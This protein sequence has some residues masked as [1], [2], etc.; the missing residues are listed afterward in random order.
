MQYRNIQSL[1]EKQVPLFIS[2]QAVADPCGSLTYGQLNTAANKVAHL[3]LSAGLPAQSVVGMLLD[4]GVDAVV[5][6]LGILKAGLVF[7]PVDPRQPSAR[8]QRILT[9]SEAPFLIG[10]KKY[11]GELNRLQ[12]QCP[13]LR[14]VFCIDSDDFY[15]EKESTDNDLHRQLWDH[16]GETAT[17]DISGGGWTSSYDGRPFSRAE[18]DEYAENTWQKVSPY[19]NPGSRVLEIGCASGIT[20]F[21]IAP[22]VKEYIGTDISAA[23][24]KNTG[25]AVRERNMHNIRLHCMAACDIKSLDTEK[26]DVIIINSVVQSFGGLNYLRQVIKDAMDL[27]QPGG[28]VFLGDIMDADTKEEMVRSFK[29][30]KQDNLDPAVVT[31][32]TWDTELFVSRDFL[33]DLSRSIPGI[34]QVDCSRKTGTIA[35]ELTRFRYD[36]I[37]VIDRSVTVVHPGD[38]RKIQLDKHHLIP[39]TADNPGIDTDPSQL[40]YVLYTS[41]STGTPKGVMVSHGS[42]LAYVEWLTGFHQITEQDGSMVI[43]RISYDGVYPSI[44]GTL[45]A[46]GELRMLPSDEQQD[47][48]AILERLSGAAITFFVVTPTL[49]N[50]LL[51]CG[52]AEKIRQCERL[53]LVIIG[54]EAIRPGDLSAFF[55]LMPEVAVYNEY[56]P[57]EATI[58]ATTCGITRHNIAAFA[59]RPV[60]GQPLSHVSIYILDDNMQLVPDNTPGEIYIGGRSVAAGYLNNPA[61]TQEKFVQNPFDNRGESRLY[62]TGDLGR[63]LTDGNI[64]CLGRKDHQVKIR[65]HRVELGEIEQQLLLQ[66]GMLD[67]KVITRKDRDGISHLIAYIRSNVLLTVTD[68]RTALKNNLPD[69]MVPGAFVK[70]DVFPLNSSGKVDVRL[71]PSPQGISMKEDYVAPES[72]LEKQL[73]GLWE[74]VLDKTEI[75]VTENFFEAGGHSLKATRLLAAICKTF[76][77]DV[78]LRMIF[79]HPTIASQAAVIAEHTQPLLAPIPEQAAAACYDCSHAQRRIWV[80]SQL[81]GASQAYTEVGSVQLEGALD[82]PALE[83]AIRLACV[84]HESLRTYFRFVDGELKQFIPVPEKTSFQLR[85]IDFTHYTNTDRIVRDFISTEQHTLFDLAQGPLFRVSVIRLDAGR[86]LLVMAYHH[87]I[88]DGISLNIIMDETAQLYAGKVLMPLRI[89]YKDFAHWQN[90]QIS[91]PVL[92]THRNYWRQQLNGPLPVLDLT[93]DFSRPEMKSYNGQL[94]THTF[95]VSLK[96]VLAQQ[97]AG[98]QSTLF[99]ILVAA[100]KTLLYRYTEQTDIIVG[101]PISGREHPEL[102]GQVGL[103]L[104]MLPLRTVIDAGDSFRTLL[105]KVKAGSAMAYTHQLYPFD[106]LVDELQLPADTSRTPLFDIAVNLYEETEWQLPGLKT[107]RCSTGHSNSKTDIAFNFVESAGSLSLRLEYCADLFTA[108]RMAGMAA[109]LEVLLQEIVH[110]MD[111]P[112]WQLNYLTAAEHRTLLETFNSAVEQTPEDP[113]FQ[114]LLEAQFRNNPEKQAVVCGDVIMTYGELDHKSRQ[115]AAH[116]INERAVKP[117]DLVALML[118]RSIHLLPAILGILR[119]GAAYVAIDPVDRGGHLQFILEDSRYKV[120]LTEIKYSHR[121]TDSPHIN[122]EQLS[123]TAVLPETVYQSSDLFYVMYTS[124]SSGKP[125]GVRICNRS[126]VNFLISMTEEPGIAPGDAVL[127]V[128]NYIFDISVLELL[129]P[130]TIGAYVILAVRSQLENVNELAALIQRSRPSLMQAT[131][132]IWRLLLE[133]GWQGKE[134]MKL[135]CGGEKMD[136]RLA[137]QLLDGGADVWNMYGPTETTVWSSIKKVTPGTSSANVG[138][139]VRNTVMYI[140]DSR[141]QLL[142][143]GV[144]GEICIG[145]A[146]VAQGYHYRP[147]LTAQ[148]FI[149]NPFVMEDRLYATGDLGKWTENGEIIIAGRTDSQVKINGYRLELE[150]LEQAATDFGI[151]VA[152]ADIKG[153]GAGQHIN[154]CYKCAQAIDEAALMEHITGNL[155]SAYWPANIFRITEVPLTQGGKLDRARLPDREAS[156]LPVGP[157]A[158]SSSQE[159]QFYA[160]V[161]S[162]LGRAQVDGTEDFFVLGGNS[163]KAIQLITRIDNTFKIK[164]PLSGIF[165]HT[166]LSECWKFISGTAVRSFLPFAGDANE[167]PAPASFVQKGFYMMSRLEAASRVF[168]LGSSIR[169]KGRLKIEALVAAFRLLIDRHTILRT[170]FRWEQDEL[171]QEIYAATLSRFELE[172]ESL[173]GEEELDGLVADR[174][175]EILDTPFVFAPYSPLF[176]AKLLHLDNEEYLL[177]LSMHH[178]IGD[179]YSFNII[180]RELAYGYNNMPMNELP[181]QYTD[182]ARWENQAIRTGAF[183]LH[184]K[185]WQQQFEKEV[186]TLDLKEDFPQ[187]KRTFSGNTTRFDVPAI[188]ADTWRA[189][190]GQYQVSPFMLLSAI[191]KV[192]LYKYSGERDIVTGIPVANRSFSG[193]ENQLGPYVN[194]VAVRSV[195]DP[196]RNF[197]SFLQAERVT[198]MDAFDHQIYPFEMLINELDIK[199]KPGRTPL[200]DVMITY[201]AAVEEDTGSLFDDLEIE[202][203][204]TKGNQSQFALSFDFY[205]QGG[206]LTAG[207]NYNSH[208]FEA[209]TIEIIKSRLLVLMQE[210]TDHPHVPLSELNIRLKIE[211]KREKRIQ[212]FDF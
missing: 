53:R 142:P 160:I 3:L 155:P 85:V 67:A 207:I 44:W 9:E 93:T 120:M 48:V 193:M 72:T 203:A 31:K 41:G 80:L 59:R 32:T 198:L 205:E 165:R 124:G 209:V 172:T 139:P 153:E 52:Q 191:V 199:V 40:A 101:L 179:L 50:M 16:I 92:E 81:E 175:Q 108:A 192:F 77:I 195:L 75:G 157:S 127:A 13:A 182:Y 115:V 118:D 99:M 1:F 206:I 7:M 62:K 132:S 82:L 100:V 78:K 65:G 71:L 111:L 148:K 2:R 84:R 126:V 106:K 109:H 169:L 185:Y 131:P 121:F 105:G 162:V 30:Y 186:P 79:D 204:E 112:L 128:T 66:P 176:R 57:T 33:H 189:W 87:I 183:T 135:L 149:S 188:L 76:N 89:Q 5:S 36:A 154:L 164:V 200:F 42:V 117:G 201:A 38:S 147:G 88:M 45:L 116:L 178:I 49:F 103:Y 58:V 211:E 24:I 146:G 18:M 22:F 184:K 196:E 110:H 114:Q 150:E 167:Q 15:A 10:Q 177:L 158:T 113:V 69:Y 180:L 29:A 17:D 70:L 104:N 152:I 125:K 34:V 208:A 119:A 96:T 54:G 37:L 56:G 136:A 86:H 210:I 73:A 68:I 19:L 97:V 143:T 55:A 166:R 187:E 137:S 23:I 64:E 102:Q 151:P 197:I 63:W 21:R 163:L 94:Y 27:L 130:L 170:A 74:K 173:Y 8:I 12:W 91:S 83:N 123:G 20:M 107:Q 51:E 134:G 138:R 39:F 144:M 194:A 174:M 141:Y 90:E 4:N 212:E 28:I 46:G 156:T 190:S 145:G 171:V 95:P 43:S 14:F 181:Y 61:L 202:Q 159:L 60:I 47:P 6:I 161:A 129:A 25:K 11:M 35:N 133:S 168:N 26:V 98:T 122:I 140:L